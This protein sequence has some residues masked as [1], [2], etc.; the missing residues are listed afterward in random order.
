MSDPT[1]ETKTAES[2]EQ[3]IAIAIAAVKAT[4]VTAIDSTGQ[5]EIDAATVVDALIAAGLVVVTPEATEF[6]IK[7]FERF[8]AC[9]E[10]GTAP[11]FSDQEAINDYLFEALEQLSPRVTGTGKDN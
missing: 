9:T 11:I 10:E 3:A 8:K 6:P 2:R 4:P 7:E 1:A 5:A